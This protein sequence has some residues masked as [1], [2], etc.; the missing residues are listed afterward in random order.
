MKRLI[1]CC[2]GTWNKPDEKDRGVPAP[3]NVAKTYA[4][5]M[6]AGA[7]G[8]AQVKYYDTG[9][10]TGPWYD[11]WVGGAFGVGLSQNIV[12]AYRWVVDT[13][14]D[15][16]ELFLLGFSRGAYTVR[17]LAGLI[18]NS[19]LL[20][21]EHAGRI[22][23]AYALY[24]RRDPRSGPSGDDAKAFRAAYARE[25]RIRFIGVWDTV[26]ALGIPFGPMRVF[27]W[28]RLTFHDVKL[29]SYVDYAYQALA[30][31]ELRRPFKPSIWQQQEHSTG[32]VMEQRWFA[33]T[34]S[35]VGGGYADAGLSD[36]A[37]EWMRS[38]A[39]ACG[40]AYDAAYVARSIRASERG[41]LRASNGGFWRLLPDYRRPI[42][43]QQSGNEDVASSAVDRTREDPGYAP[44]NLLTWLK[45][46]PAAKVAT[47]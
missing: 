24:R 19:G 8:V 37:F 29:S 22:D 6:A 16:D 41:E 10:G 18:R 15:G 45:R 46:G 31:D 23:E 12:Q 4:A 43:A 5:L 7:Q 14:E 35:N 3:T 11:R 38:R 44:R 33:G 47:G 21:R 28:G 42:G 17:S 40:L 27:T 36:L 2:D 32:Q 25:I 39:E 13:W 9:V 20:R 26:G 30:V 1:V 34:H